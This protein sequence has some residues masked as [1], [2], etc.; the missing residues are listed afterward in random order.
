MQKPTLYKIADQ[1]GALV[2]VAA[3][4]FSIAILPT[5][6]DQEY[7]AEHPTDVYISPSDELAINWNDKTSK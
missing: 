4:I 6:C 7:A 3:F 1:I 2:G 5:S